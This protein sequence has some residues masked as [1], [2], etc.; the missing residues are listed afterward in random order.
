MTPR[1]T[2][3][4]QGLHN[5]AGWLAVPE[6]RAWPIPAPHVHSDLIGHCLPHFPLWTWV[7]GAPGGGPGLACD[8]VV[9]AL[10]GLRPLNMTP[11]TLR[12]YQ[13]RQQSQRVL[14]QSLSG[15][16]GTSN[17]GPIHDQAQ[18]VP[19][20]VPSQGLQRNT[21]GGGRVSDRQR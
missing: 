1:G 19:T 5:D 8:D 11:L 9:F 14:K 21:S 4:V 15:G 2:S 16:D 7:M 3:G 20:A 18:P 13:L 6:P 17:N 10:I 12:L